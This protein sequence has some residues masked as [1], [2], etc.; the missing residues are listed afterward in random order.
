MNHDQGLL[1][2]LGTRHYVVTWL[3][4]HS[5]KTPVSKLSDVRELLEGVGKEEV[6]EY[7]SAPL[8]RACQLLKSPGKTSNK[9]DG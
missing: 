6:G 4:F 1:Q 2:I 5:F 7:R 9:R 3:F 8:C